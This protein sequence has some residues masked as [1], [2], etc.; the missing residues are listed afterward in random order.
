[1]TNQAQGTE[2]YC[3]NIMAVYKI[4][5]K[6]KWNDCKKNKLRVLLIQ[7]KES[8]WWYFFFFDK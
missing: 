7:E 6:K 1:M 5:N 8:L 4:L 2:E 3:I